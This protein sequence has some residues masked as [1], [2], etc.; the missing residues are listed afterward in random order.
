MISD[1]ERHE[2]AERLCSIIYY[3]DDEA[4]METCDGVDIIEALGLEP[5]GPFLA[6]DFPRSEVERLAKL[7]DRPT[8]HMDCTET[9]DTDHGK[10]RVWECDECGRECEEVNGDYEY[11]PHCGAKVIKAVKHG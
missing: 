9:I 6:D 3:E 7:I 4:G 5:T 8:C 2:V 1:K 10:V 11:C